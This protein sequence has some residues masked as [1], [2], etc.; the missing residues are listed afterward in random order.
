MEQH[1]NKMIAGTL[2]ALVLAAGCSSG[3]SDT[4]VV[5]PPPP[6]PTSFNQF[7]DDQFAATADDTDPVSVDDVDFAFDE[8]PAA[9]E[10]LLQ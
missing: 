10:T 7:V 8:D 3:G 2:L 1:K 9:F 5:M 6:A 4:P